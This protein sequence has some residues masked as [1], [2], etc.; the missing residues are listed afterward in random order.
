MPNLCASNAADLEGLL[1][2]VGVVG[3]GVEGGNG[4]VRL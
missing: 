3:A 2:E 4:G 1:V